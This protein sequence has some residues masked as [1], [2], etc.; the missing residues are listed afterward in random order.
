[1]F[2]NDTATTEIYTRAADDLGDRQTVEQRVPELEPD[3][4]RQETTELDRHR[5]VQPKPFAQRLD[6]P[7]LGVD[8]EHGGGR[9]SRHQPQQHERHH[10]DDEH[11][12]DQGEDAN[13]D[14]SGES[15]HDSL[16]SSSRGPAWAG[17]RSNAFLKART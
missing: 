11:G 14:V 13:R 17:P 1:M 15:T 4:S 12:G 7:E 10:R 3:D 9:I 5:G 6:L 8:G 2:F 16:P